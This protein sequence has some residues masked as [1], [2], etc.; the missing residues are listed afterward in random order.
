MNILRSD[1][2]HGAIFGRFTSK[3]HAATPARTT[4]FS[5]ASHAQAGGADE[6]RAS[7]L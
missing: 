7:D 6:A 1:H 3:R 4:G 5:P 2:G